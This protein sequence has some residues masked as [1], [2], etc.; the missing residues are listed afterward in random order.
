MVVHDSYFESENYSDSDVE[1]FSSCFDLGTI[2]RFHNK[3][4]I[5]KSLFEAQDI[6][7]PNLFVVVVANSLD[8]LYCYLHLDK[9]RL[10]TCIVRNLLKINVKPHWGRI[11]TDVALQFS[12]RFDF[13]KFF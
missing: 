11:F 12:S 13:T 5:N 10:L 1:H 2:Y 4:L 3:D 8:G 7:K 6:C 9:H